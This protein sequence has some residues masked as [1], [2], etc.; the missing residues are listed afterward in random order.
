[1]RPYPPF[2]LF[3]FPFPSLPPF[4][5]LPSPPTSCPPPT[6]ILIAAGVHA[7]CPAPSWHLQAATHRAPPLRRAC[8][9]RA[10]ILFVPPVPLMPPCFRFCY[11][12]CAIAQRFCGSFQNCHRHFTPITDVRRRSSHTNSSTSVHTTHQLTIPISCYPQST[13]DK[14]T[15][16]C[17]SLQPY[18]LLLATSASPSSRNS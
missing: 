18:R 12:T 15:L 9:R 8:S 3:S 5:F 17:L 7:I 6:P 13:V 1:M 14:R 4:S 11:F 2:S 16:T 10:R